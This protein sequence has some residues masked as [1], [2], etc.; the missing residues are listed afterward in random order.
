VHSIS[1]RTASWDRYTEAE[2]RGGWS[3][4]SAI[5]APNARYIV[6]PVFNREE[7]IVADLNLSEID[8]EFLALDVSG[9]YSRS[10]VFA[11]ETK[12]Q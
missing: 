4:T 12:A 9:H 3:R 6:E 8:H 11:F 10:E 5:I 1:S 7:L 2:P